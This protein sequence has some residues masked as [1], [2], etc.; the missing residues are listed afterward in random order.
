M[1]VQ[2]RRGSGSG[3]AAENA[4]LNALC[5]AAGSSSPRAAERLR[6]LSVRP[7]AKSTVIRSLRRGNRHHRSLHVQWE[8]PV[9]RHRGPASRQRADTPDTRAYPAWP[10]RCERRRTSPYARGKGAGFQP[11]CNPWNMCG[12]LVLFEASSTRW[13]TRPTLTWQT[14]EAELA[15]FC[16][17]ARNAC[18]QYKHPAVGD[19]RS[20][21]KPLSEGT[22]SSRPHS[23]VTGLT[24]CCWPDGG[25][26]LQIRLDPSPVPG[27][28]RSSAAKERAWSGWH[29]P[30]AE[31]SRESLVVMAP[32]T[33]K[34]S[35]R[36][37][38]SDPVIPEASCPSNR[39]RPRHLDA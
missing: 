39:A 18:W 26:F 37:Q 20:R 28:P 25:V 36:S 3:R 10:I 21:P 24:T 15:P 31:P 11:S 29:G 4:S 6:V 35:H 12:A 30:G 23:L 5:S 2:L 38:P 16:N 8:Q 13:P 7:K 27:P 1:P 14:S 9:V 34:A 33:R 19:G 22:G 32:T 17:S